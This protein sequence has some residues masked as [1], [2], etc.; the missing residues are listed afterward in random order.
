[1]FSSQANSDVRPS[2]AA[3]I[4]IS[5]GTAMIPGFQRRLE[6]SLRT[7]IQTE[8]RYKPLRPLLSSHLVIVPTS[9]KPNLLSW[10]GGSA[11]GGLKIHCQEIS[12]EEYLT[13]GRVTPDWSSSLL[14]ALHKNDGHDAVATSGS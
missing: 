2:L 13:R 5:G 14:S 7:L 1:M 6:S 3:S 8:E 11:V 10:Q 12:A 4:V 9:F